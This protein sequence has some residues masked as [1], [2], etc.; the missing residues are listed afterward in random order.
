M[1][2]EGP[3]RRAD[4]CE[5]GDWAHVDVYLTRSIDYRAVLFA[6]SRYDDQAMGWLSSRGSVVVAVGADV[7][8]AALSVR[9]RDDDDPLVALLTE[10]LVVE[11]LAATWWR[12]P[13]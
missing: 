11:L 7:P 3:R 9:Y 12:A 8:G 1:L 10:T 4:A 6:G 13:A 2:R 5:T